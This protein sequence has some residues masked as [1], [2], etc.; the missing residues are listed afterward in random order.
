MADVLGI[1][2]S[3]LQVIQTGV[4]VSICLYTFAETVSSAGKAIKE[5]YDDI[6]STNKVL[7]Q[8]KIILE[9]EK[10]NGTASE[11]ALADAESTVNDC[12]KVF[13][14][15]DELIR[16]HALE[17][18]TPTPSK[19]PWKTRL[20]AL[21]WPMIQPKVRLYRSSLQKHKTNLILMTQTLA[22]AKLVASE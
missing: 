19:T 14:A 3:I 4:Q 17:P 11:G 10:L 2:A 12:L 20:N 8:L 1:A 18:V 5:L 6:Q 21:K 13:N 22:Y 15:I 16:K 7:D 9:S